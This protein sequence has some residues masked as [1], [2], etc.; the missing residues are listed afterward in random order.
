MM[1]LYDTAVSNIKTTSPQYPDYSAVGLIL[2]LLLIITTEAVM[3]YYVEKLFQN[4]LTGNCS[5]GRRIRQRQLNRRW[6]AAIE[7]FCEEN[8]LDSPHDGR[9]TIAGGYTVMDGQA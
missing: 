2:A 1:K 9:D 5:L 7:Q 4:V 6:N 8:G 3:I